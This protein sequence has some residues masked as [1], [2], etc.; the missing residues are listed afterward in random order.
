[1]IGCDAWSDEPAFGDTRVTGVCGSG[2]IEA[3]AE[4]HLAGVLTTDGT[5][6]GALAKRTSA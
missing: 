6:D 1:M 5:I 4:L 2:I 3:I